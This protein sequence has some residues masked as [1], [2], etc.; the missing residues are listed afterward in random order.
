MTGWLGSFP[1]IMFSVVAVL[2]WAA[3]NMRRPRVD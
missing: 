1:A 2:A 3:G